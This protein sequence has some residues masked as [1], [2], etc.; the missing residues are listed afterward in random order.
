[1]RFVTRSADKAGVIGVIVTAMGCAACFPAIASLGAVIGLGFLSRVE[2]LFITVLMPVFALVALVAYV[3]SWRSHRQW[4]RMLPGVTGALLVLAAA[5]LMRFLGW[6]TAWLLYPGLALMSAASL[7]DLL[8]P[9][10]GVC[11]TASDTGRC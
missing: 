11:A 9:P 3:I 1:M 4:Q 6:P 7:W 10:T 2:G 8:S 5:I